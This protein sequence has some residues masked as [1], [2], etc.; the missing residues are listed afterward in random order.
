[1]FLHEKIEQA[2]TYGVYQDLPS[3]IPANLN[4][5]FELRPYQCMA[6]QNFFTYFETPALLRKPSQALFHMATGS[7]KTLIMAGL[8]L[9][10]YKHG[11][12]NFLFFVNLSNIVKKTEDNFLNKASSKYL[13]AEEIIIDGERVPIRKVNNF[14][15]SDP[16][17]INICF[18]TTQGLHTRLN[19][20]SENAVTIDDFVERKTVLIS[21]EAHHLNVSTKKAD[22]EN[23]QTWEY[24][25]SR[26]FDSNVNNVLLEFTATC[27]LS[28][29]DIHAKYEP[30][31]VF[32]YPLA[33][34]RA[35]LYS[36]EILTLRSDLTIMDRALQAC[37]LSQYRL[38][39]FQDNRIPMK[40]IVLFKAAKI[41][42]SKNFM[43]AFAVAI[44]GL[45]GD[46]LARIASLSTSETMNKAYTYF[47]DKEISLDTL[48]QELRNDFSI[49]H[50]ISA[51][52]DSEAEK[53]QLFLN[54]L[55]NL[56][57]PYRAVFEVK[58]LD[59]GWDVLNLFDIVRL[60]ETGRSSNNRISATTVSEAQLIGRGARYCP[61]RAGPDE[62][63]YQRKYDHDPDA[64]LRI[65]EE[66][67]YHC[68][69]DSRYIA[70][71]RNAL[72]EIGVELE[73]TVKRNYVLK[74]DF[75]QDNP[76][77]EGRVFANQKLK[78]NRSDVNG[79]LP[80]V[81]D[82]VYSV[83]LAT[84][85]GGEDVVMDVDDAHE[86]GTNA[87]IVH[88]S[89]KEI[90]NSNYALVH[91][92]LRKY[93]EFKFNTL[94]SYFPNLTGI[95]EFVYSDK[96]LGNVKIEITSRYPIPPLSVLYAVC[97]RV[98][99]KI[100][101]SLSKIEANAEFDADMRRI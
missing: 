43:A 97:S 11:Y 23:E 4:P 94:Q 79:L 70:E 55:E 30:L 32:D 85:R 99:G 92:V 1:M 41:D 68:Q 67:H 75:K 86:S 90:A 61:L 82:K 84:G 22:V 89:I 8:M 39:V 72:R 12:R 25:V 101:D 51:N 14:Q 35:D 13:F 52:D 44:G 64:P 2:R 63:K 71:L 83:K 37:I 18:T 42:D 49:E 5:A 10:L 88:T 29:R 33:K 21:D 100:A 78:K 58:K 15:F 87:T 81:R 48:A 95:R 28:N 53:N 36:K 47:R 59:E 3:Y 16:D 54:S 40:P 76:D 38:K 26:I 50:C 98:L 27:N 6:F 31:I 45:T 46:E 57:S 60:Y 65:C 69:N 34:F 73:N 7:G 77:K 80:S 17:A 19:F 24:T 91:K 74:D 66:L 20:P 62:P 56:S 9:Y 93:N 96:Y